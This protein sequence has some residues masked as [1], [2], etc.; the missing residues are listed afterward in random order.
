LLGCAERHGISKIY[1]AIVWS[2]NRSTKRISLDRVFRN[3]QT[4]ESPSRQLCFR[5]DEKGNNV[6]EVKATMPDAKAV[7]ESV[8]AWAADNSKFAGRLATGMPTAQA[9]TGLG[10]ELLRGN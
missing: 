6:E 9:L 2:S 10:L 3:L 7:A 1:W 5:S 4:K 8:K